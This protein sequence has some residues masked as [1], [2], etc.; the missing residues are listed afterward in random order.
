MKKDRQLTRLR[1]TL[2]VLREHAQY[3]S[4]QQVAKRPIQSRLSSEPYELPTQTRDH[5]LV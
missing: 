2:R 1:E 5:A 3:R 4:V